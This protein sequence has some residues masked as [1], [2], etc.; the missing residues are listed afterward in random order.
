MIESLSGEDEGLDLTPSSTT[1]K[2]TNLN[3][4]DA[5]LELTFRWGKKIDTNIKMHRMAD[6]QRCHRKKY[7]RG[8]VG[9][10]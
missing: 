1:D 5:L 10:G 2:H 6:V 8:E 9:L 4:G 3:K 7:R